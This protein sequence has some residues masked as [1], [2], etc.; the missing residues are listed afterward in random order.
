MHR[1]T[2]PGYLALVNYPA[3]PVLVAGV[4]T[5]VVDVQWL[6]DHASAPK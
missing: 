2:E 6:S 4:S 5:S 1:W 3:A